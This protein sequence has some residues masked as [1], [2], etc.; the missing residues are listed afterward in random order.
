MA[1]VPRSE[2]PRTHGNLILV[3]DIE[4]NLPLSYVYPRKYHEISHRGILTAVPQR[5]ILKVHEDL[6]FRGGRGLKLNF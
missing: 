5:T 4:S 3:G 2:I 1:V 6:F